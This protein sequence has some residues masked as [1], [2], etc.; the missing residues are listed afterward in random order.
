[1]SSAIFGRSWSFVVAAAGRAGGAKAA[2]LARRA[3]SV[4]MALA[5]WW[6]TAVFCSRSAFKRSDSLPQ[7]AAA[8]K[9]ALRT[10][11]LEAVMVQ[12]SVE[13]V[14][15]KATRLLVCLCANALQQ[16]RCLQEA[17]RARR[18]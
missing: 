1:M 13:G 16:R 11:A 7:L 2:A 9:A 14:V 15:S 12:L 6:C 8:L 18:R 10:Y 4:R 3:R 17:A 5:A